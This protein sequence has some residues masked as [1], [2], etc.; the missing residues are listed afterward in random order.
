MSQWLPA[1]QSPA[2]PGTSPE[3]AAAKEE[4]PGHSVLCFIAWPWALKKVVQGVP[5]TATPAAT[6]G[7]FWG[8]PS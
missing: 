2:E 8:D 1:P 5:G 6:H 3:G 7:L 4:S